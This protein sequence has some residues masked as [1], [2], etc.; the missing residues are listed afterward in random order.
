MGTISGGSVR[1]S[2]GCGYRGGISLYGAH[3]GN[4]EE[5]TATLCC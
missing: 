4:V 5:L 2:A 3:T 1:S